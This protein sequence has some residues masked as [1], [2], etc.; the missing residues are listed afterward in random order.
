MWAGGDEVNVRNS[1]LILMDGGS[2]LIRGRPSRYGGWKQIRGSL[3]TMAETEFLS[4]NEDDLDNIPL[5]RFADTTNISAD[6][7]DNIP[8]I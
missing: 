6:D 8:L 7:F 3:V 5:A 4:D 2:S 1:D